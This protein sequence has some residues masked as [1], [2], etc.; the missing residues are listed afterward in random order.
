[1]KKP[2]YEQLAFENELLRKQL[3]QDSSHLNQLF[4]L[5]IEEAEHGIFVVQNNQLKYANRKFL[6]LL[7]YN[8]NEL[9]EIHFAEFIHPDYREKI[10]DKFNKLLTCEIGAF[11]NTEM[12]VIDDKEKEKCLELESKLVNWDEKSAVM[13][14]VRDI[15]EEKER[16]RAINAAEDKLK[17]S[18]KFRESLVSRLSHEIR[19]PMTAIIGFTDLLSDPSL[20]EDLKEKYVH[21]LNKSGNLLLNLIDNI[22]DLVQ[23]E[24]GELDIKNR[25]F[26][27]NKL[28]DNLYNQFRSELEKTENKELQFRL[29]KGMEGNFKINSD[30][31]KIRQVLSNL[32][33]NAFKYT[34]QG[35][36]EFGYNKTRNNVLQFHVKDT[37]VGIFRE[38]QRI[39][40]EQFYN[41]DNKSTKHI[42]SGL[43]LTISRA[44]IEKMGGQITV[45]SEPD[46]GSHFYFTLPA[47][48]LEPESE[49]E[50]PTDKQSKY[51][52]SGKNILV[53][54]DVD[55]N[56]VFV[57]A[58]L[59]KTKAHVIR[60]Q[61]GQEAVEIIKENP[62]DIVLMDIQMPKMN[63]YEATRKILEKNPS[64]PVIAQT[65]F[66][67]EGERERSLEAGC[68]DYLPKPIKLN[69]LLETVG[70]HIY[71]SE[72]Q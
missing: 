2:S 36:I 60:A 8:F 16:E 37:G 47:E 24:A 42:G 3:N 29:T 62:V 34:S 67:M 14:F 54:E 64:I 66:V 31:D 18:L 48:E 19:T 15:T 32:L 39:I 28:M 6:Q 44:V 13:S 49:K 5:I 22:I 38:K 56:F 52:W 63:G 30:E 46:K 59:R 26:Q 55:T 58:A 53:A 72:K 40:F 25:N 4:H 7:G 27:L 35:H 1:M 51:Q 20:S 12:W 21:Y 70:K 11:E 65:A 33:E 10:I 68:V 41:P 17:A 50:I 9:K 23:M 61:N 71:K 69:Q 43:G 45:D 57:E